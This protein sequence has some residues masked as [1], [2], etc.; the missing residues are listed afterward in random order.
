M[1]IKRCWLKELGVNRHI[2][3]NCNSR[4]PTN[5]SELINDIVTCWYY[6]VLVVD[7]R[8]SMEH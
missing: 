6:M 8:M 7:E 3:A 4:T 1:N 2:P 5:K